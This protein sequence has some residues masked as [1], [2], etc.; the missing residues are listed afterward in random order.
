MTEKAA[1]CRNDF[2]SGAESMERAPRLARAFAATPPSKKSLP[3]KL[4]ESKPIL[5]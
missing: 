2:R 4:L 1:Q 5:E 3:A